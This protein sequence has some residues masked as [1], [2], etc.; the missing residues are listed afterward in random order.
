[1]CLESH[2]EQAESPR[3]ALGLHFLGATRERK[4]T[5]AKMLR[6]ATNQRSK[7]SSNNVALSLCNRLL[8]LDL[9]LE[10]DLEFGL[11]HF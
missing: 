1:M 9:F 2:L 4:R 11:K 3:D 8:V 10:H 5:A 6:V 7:N